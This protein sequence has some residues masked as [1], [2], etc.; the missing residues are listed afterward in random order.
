MLHSKW[1]LVFSVTE[2]PKS[3]ETVNNNSHFFVCVSKYYYSFSFI[4][5]TGANIWNL[6]LAKIPVNLILLKEHKRKMESG[7]VCSLNCQRSQAEKSW[8]SCSHCRGPGH[9]YRHLCCSLGLSH[10]NMGCSYWFSDH[11]WSE[12]P[13]DSTLMVSAKDNVDTVS[14]LICWAIPVIYGVVMLQEVALHRPRSLPVLPHSSL[15]Q[16]KEPKIQKNMS[17]IELAGVGDD[18]MFAPSW[19]S[20]RVW[21]IWARMGHFDVFTWIKMK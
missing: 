2:Q 5:T 10:G 11:T 7:F 9:E 20:Q 16:N 1:Y 19:Q 15:S 14:L 12:T 4:P 8:R 6:P 21:V 18:G 17:S 13:H 3:V